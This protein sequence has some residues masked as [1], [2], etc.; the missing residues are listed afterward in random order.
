MVPP[1]RC[2]PPYN[3]HHTLCMRTLI[4]TLPLALPTEAMPCE[5]T[6]I[7]DSGAVLRTQT[8]PLTLLATAQGTDVVVL[9]PLQKL[10]WYQVQLPRGTLGRGYFQ[11]AQSQRL[12]TVLDGLLEDRLLDEPGDLHMA[13]QAQAQTEQASWVAVCDHAWLSAWLHTLEQATQVVSRI[14][15]ELAP[16]VAAQEQ[17]AALYVMGSPERA[18]V[19]HASTQG[20]R[21]LPLNGASVSLLNAVLSQDT[22]GTVTMWAEPGV[23]ELAEHLFKQPARLL[24]RSQRAAQAL[25]NGWDLAQFD[26]VRTRRTR[27]RKQLRQLLNTLWHSP[28]WRPARVALLALVLVNLVGLNWLASSTRAD[29]AKQ[30]AAIQAVLLSTFPDVR[31]V[32]DAPAQMTRAVAD[33]QRQSGTAA[34]HDLESLLSQ[35]ELAA[36]GSGGPKALRYASGELQLQGLSPD[37]APLRDITARLQTQGYNARWD[38]STLVIT[39]EASP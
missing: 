26:L 23:A 18:Q 16:S 39:A 33:M 31:V 11:E 22:D 6:L 32:V 14:V 7:D 21:L 30:Q 8:T 12:R 4:I 9:V 13:L 10:A 28:V 2:Y 35:F 24:S 37:A 20:L 15:P 1:P 36:P 3:E 38:N 17:P 34:R 5:T 29:Q 19:A 25:H 27:T